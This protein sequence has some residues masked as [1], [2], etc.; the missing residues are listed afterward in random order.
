MSARLIL[1]VLVSALI[2][3]GVSFVLWPRSPR[4]RE[5]VATL[6]GM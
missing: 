1:I 4:T 6:R 3:A 5:E 2:I